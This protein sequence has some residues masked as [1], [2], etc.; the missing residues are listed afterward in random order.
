MVGFTLDTTN[1]VID[2][3]GN[4]TAFSLNAA[5]EI[6]DATGKAVVVSYKKFTNFSVNTANKVVNGAGKVT[7]FTLN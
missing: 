2:L 4:L 6:V 3:A 1:R 5:G 7:Y